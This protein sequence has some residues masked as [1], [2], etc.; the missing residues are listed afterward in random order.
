MNY[1]YYVRRKT[2]WRRSTQSRNGLRASSKYSDDPSRLIR[3]TKH[4]T[5]NLSFSYTGHGINC[6]FDKQYIKL[7][8][9]FCSSIYIK[10]IWKWFAIFH[11]LFKCAFITLSFWMDDD[12][13]IPHYRNVQKMVFEQTAAKYLLPQKWQIFQK[14]FFF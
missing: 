5:F 4:N 9:L 1:N 6:S 3:S 11:L 12:L 10:N 2:E 7:S 14:C 13:H 8:R